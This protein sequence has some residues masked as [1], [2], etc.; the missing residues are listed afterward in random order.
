MT[1][2][3]GLR[4][5]AL[6]TVS[7]LA[8]A[9]A[10]VAGPAFGQAQTQTAQAGSVEEIVV[11]GTRIVRDG[12][13]APTPLTVVTAEALQANTAT[14][15]IADTLNTMPAFANSTSP[16]SSVNGISAATQGLNI[17]NLRSMGGNRTLV[18][19]DGQRSVPAL[20][21]GEVDVNNFPQQLISRVDTVTGGGSAVYGSDAVA[22]VVNFVLDK[23]FVGVKGEISGGE[24]TYGDD[25][26][27][28]FSLAGGMAFGGDR[29]H[30]L[31]SAEMARTEGITPGDGGP[32][33]K[34]NYSGWGIM[35]NPAYGTGAGQST[36]VPQQLVRQQI[37]LSNATHGGIIVSGPLKGTAFGEGG[38]PFQFNYGSITNAPWMQ[39]GDWQST[40][41]RHDRSGTLDPRNLRHNAFFR[42]SYDVTDDVNVYAQLSWGD[43]ITFTSSWP[44]FQAG[45]GATILSGN[46]FIPASVQAQMTALKITSFTIGSMNY[47][48]PNVKNEARRIT[49]RYVVGSEGKFN[50]MDTGWSWNAYYQYG[51]TK[52]TT[53]VIDVLNLNNWRLATDAVL[54]PN[55]NI[56]CRSTLTNPTNGCVP[57]NNLGTGVN[58]NNTAAYKY[59]F[60]L[61]RVIQSI[62][63]NVFAGS[64][65]GEPFSTWAGPVSLALSMEYRHEKALGRPDPPLGTTTWFAGN[66]SPF[67]ATNYVTEGA[68]ETVI[69]LAKDAVWAESF[70]LN[71]A[72]RVTDY[73]LS[74]VVTTW[75]VGAVW[76]LIPDI[77]IRGTRSRDIR[78]PNFNE[79][80]AAASSGFRS[81]FDPFTNTI[82]QFFGQNNGNP[83][84]VPEKGDTYEFGV[85]L[86]PQFFPGFTAS[87]DYWNINLSGAIG[88]ANDNQTLAFCFAG[89]QEFCANIRRDPPLPGQSIG[90]INLLI[91][92]PYN[93]ASNKKSGLD[94]EVSYNLP[95]D[96]VSPS[97]A[98]DLGFR[99]QMTRYLTSSQ[100]DGLGGG[101]INTL[102]QE[103]QL[104]TGPPRWR[105]TGTLSYALD[106]LRTSLTMRSQG[107]GVIDNRYIQ[108]SSGC[109]AVVGNAVTI[110]NNRIGGS[111]YMDASVSYRMDVSGVQV[112]PF[113]TVRN[114]LNADP[115]IV[116]QGPTDFT[117]TSSLSKG[118]SGFDILGRVFRAG[119]R[120][121]M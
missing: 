65:T 20:F 106:G 72:M 35:I 3:S 81:A 23:K 88:G 58:V 2:S 114:L 40:E 64:V 28:K 45:N 30:I 107:A 54:A 82:P 59:N 52:A 73:K 32:D 47:D 13:E 60:G 104:L 42:A 67:G 36:S 66:F 77:R 112:E 46:P 84:L 10:S 89:R 37:S 93:L 69:P 53:D 113:L 105:L 26:N 115:T 12:Y 70:D 15:N 118:S 11:T 21:S 49:T 117:Y 24:T 76:N 87:V 74:G 41:I 102:G 34:W 5:R 27:Y 44:P 95:M 71:A 48:M 98:G 96:S 94:F 103:G 9:A 111:F 63:Q 31:M 39:G 91:Q 18:L 1:T 7:V 99:G 51:K 14:A 121:K 43:N 55:G 97:F 33:R 109:P 56:V 50:A 4:V 100:D 83:N 85:V 6:T 120:F 8:L 90:V 22:G 68:V 38:V 101:Y 110:E 62:Q 29:G 57:W 25:Q 86:N 80:Y 79:L 78:A 17:L 92:S 16:Q 116:P 108:C 75:K 119:L 19:L 61:S